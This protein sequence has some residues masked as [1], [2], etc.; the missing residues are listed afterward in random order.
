MAI[1]D[2]ATLGQIAI[3]SLDADPSIAGLAAPIGSLGLLDNNTNGFIWL[4]TGAANTA[5]VLIPRLASATQLA[6]NGFVFADASGNLITNT[7]RAYW[8]GAGRFSFGSNAPAAPQ[9]T[10]HLDRGTGVGSHIRFTAGTTTGQTSGDGAEFGI[11]DAGNAEIKQYEN[12]S[13]NFFTNN[14]LKMSITNTGVTTITNGTGGVAITMTPGW[15]GG[16]GSWI[17]I[18]TTGPSGIGTGG[19]GANAWIGYAASAGNWF[20]NAAAGDICYRNSGGRILW[21]ISPNNYNMAMLTNGDV[22]H[23]QG[24]RVGNTTDTTGGNIRYVADSDVQAYVGGAWRSLV[25]DGYWEASATASTTTTSSTDVL[26]SGMTLTP[27][28]GTYMAWFSGSVGQSAADN[29]VTVSIYAGGSQIAHTQRVNTPTPTF[30]A[31]AA[32]T[33]VATNGVVTVNGSQAVEIRWRR[34]AGTATCDQRTFN[35]IQVN[36]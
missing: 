10:L 36:I 34:N 26:M 12:S 22:V 13:I 5:W 28:A 11:D 23:A 21:G 29:T 3:L 2:Q 33:T 24:I 35:L 4:K 19:A 32:R 16:V 6:T 15:S 14:V 1:V 20:T 9:S 7:A 25:N 31:G 27:P 30:S 17:N 18:D 8:D